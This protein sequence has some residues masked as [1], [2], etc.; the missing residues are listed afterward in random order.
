MNESVSQNEFNFHPR[1]REF[2]GNKSLEGCSKLSQQQQIQLTKML[3]TT[4]SAAIIRKKN[5]NNVIC[6]RGRTYWNHPGNQ[7][8]R[9]LISLAKD[10]YS[11]AHNR[12]RKSL[13]VSEII[14]HVHMSDGCFVIEGGRK[15]RDQW[16]E[17]NLSFVREKVTQSLRDS[18]SFKYSSSTTRKKRRKAKVQE[19]FYG[20]IDRIVRSNT[21]VSQKISNLKQKVERANLYRGTENEGVSD[22]TMI[23]MFDAANLNILETMKKDR[24]MVNQLYCVSNNETATEIND[25]CISTISQS[26]TTT[27]L[28]APSTSISPSKSSNTISSETDSNTT[29]HKVTSSVSASMA[30]ATAT[31]QRKHEIKDI[32]SCHDMD[33]DFECTSMFS[34]EIGRL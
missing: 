29:S 33:L 7:L 14:R 22:E 28:T 30:L 34:D 26:S 6:A 4:T 16:V 19:I 18:L 9:K 31:F 2:P 24:S 15:G 11:K 8:Y 17:C 25:P 23:E 21:A 5:Q 3:P 13:I 10:Q 12:R 1:H 32:I 20:D 27:K